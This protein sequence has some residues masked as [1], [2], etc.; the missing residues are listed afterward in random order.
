MFVLPVIL[1]TAVIIP[2]GLVIAIYSK[3]NNLR[4][5]RKYI[6][7]TGEYT[8]KSWF[9][10]FLKMYTK[11]LIMC[12]LTFFEYDIPNKVISLCIF[13]AI[14]NYQLVVLKM[15]SH[16]FFLFSLRFYS[17][18]CWWCATDYCFSILNHTPW[19]NTLG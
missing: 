4:A 6:F 5:R 19:R 1:I 15:L 8:A 18:S 14:I 11:L 2:V 9:W 7:M 13:L 12:C 10:E 17:F 3:K 16:L